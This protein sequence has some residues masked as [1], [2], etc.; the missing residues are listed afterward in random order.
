[1]NTPIIQK[2]C[3]EFGRQTVQNIMNVN[4]SMVGKAFHQKYAP[5]TWILNL[6]ALTKGKYTAEELLLEMHKHKTNCIPLVNK[7]QVAKFL[8]DNGKIP[9]SVGKTI[10]NEVA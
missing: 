4:R 3:N 6:V 7:Q 8:E 2:I 1:M 10:K 5:P 9:T